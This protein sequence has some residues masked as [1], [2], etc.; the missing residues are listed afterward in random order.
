M[1]KLIAA[2]LA[3]NMTRV[4]SHLWS[5]ARD[6]NHYPIIKL[7]TEHHTLTHSDGPT[8]PSN[9]KAAQIEK[10]IMSQYADLA[11]TLKGTTM[12]AGTL[13]DNTVIYGISDV[14]EPSGHLMTNYHIVL[15]GHAGG[16]IPGNRH[17]R[18]AVP[19]AQGHRAHAH[20]PASHGHEGHLLRHLGQDQQDD[21]RDPLRLGEARALD[22][23]ARALAG[24]GGLVAAPLPARVPLDPKELGDALE[25]RRDAEGEDGSSASA[26]GAGVVEDGDV[27]DHVA[28]SAPPARPRRRARSGD[29]AAAAAR[30]R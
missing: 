15:M 7:D 11:R 21:A 26:L 13:L 22:V 30:G 6:D 9:L 12:G 17:F 23:H 2:A 20:A 29:P 18:Q 19:V 28:R 3:C 10:Y 27:A 4:Y 14:G 24:A 16:K 1:N 25:Q 5:G 8:G